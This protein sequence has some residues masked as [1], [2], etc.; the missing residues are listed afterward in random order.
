MPANFPTV[1]ME[2]L[3]SDSTSVE[4]TSPTA[5]FTSLWYNL[6][7]VEWFGLA[8]A[9]GTCTGTSTTL[10]IGVQ[11]RFN[12]G[13]NVYSYPNAAGSVDGTGPSAAAIDTLTDGSDDVNTFAYWRNILPLMGRGGQVRF[14]FVIAGTTPVFPIQEVT[15]ITVERSA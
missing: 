1:G 8:I 15:L 6:S 2:L 13:A 4:G 5:T 3:K 14:N 9:L 12:E 10:D 11:C 7:N